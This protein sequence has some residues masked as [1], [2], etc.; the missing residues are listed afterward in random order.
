MTL[1]R[2]PSR[3]TN[4][5]RTKRAKATKKL[6]GFSSGLHQVL[7]AF[8]RGGENTPMLRLEFPESTSAH[9]FRFQWYDFKKAINRQRPEEAPLA[10]SIMCKVR[11]S[12]VEF[13]H[14]D[15][16]A[17]N[18]LVEQQLREQ[19]GESLGSGSVLLS[20]PEEESR[21]SE[22]VFASWLGNKG[23]AGEEPR[24]EFQKGILPPTHPADTS[25]NDLMKK[26]MEEYK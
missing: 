17:I 11:G 13:S 7:S 6:E 5:E 3:L 15:Q 1:P 9:A 19:L 14:R 22:D 8:R 18:L 24:E 12:T 26:M 21:A 4:A 2:E 10:A 16:T 25:T 23:E 20:D